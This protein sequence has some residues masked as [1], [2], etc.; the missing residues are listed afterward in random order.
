MADG[1]G[2]MDEYEE[3]DNDGLARHD[4]CTVIGIVTTY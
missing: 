1:E 3:E 4:L 2:D